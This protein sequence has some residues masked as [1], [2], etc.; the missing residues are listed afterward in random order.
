MKF[1]VVKVRDGKAVLGPW[2]AREVVVERFLAEGEEFT[3]L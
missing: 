3:L 2:K 1:R